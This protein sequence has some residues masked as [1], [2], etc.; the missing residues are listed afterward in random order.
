ML[1]SAGAGVIAIALIVFAINLV[2]SLRHPAPAGPDPWGGHT[3]EWAT[4]SPPPR[5]NFAA[6]PPVRSFAPLLDLRTG[7]NLPARAEVPA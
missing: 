4:S 7:E 5:H 6:L 2:V 3:L 1:A